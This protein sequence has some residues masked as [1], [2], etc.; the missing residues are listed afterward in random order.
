MKNVMATVFVLAFSLSLFSQSITPNTYS[1]HDD[2]MLK[3]KRKE[4]AGIILLSAGGVVTAGGTFLIIDG[5][6]RNK[7][8]TNYGNSELNAGNAEVVVGVLG[9]IIGIAS[10]SASI[11]FFVGAHRTRKKAMAI[12]LNTEHAP[13]VYTPAFS[14]QMYPALAFQI[15]LGK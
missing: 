8:D 5:L 14:R 4:R 3:S 13:L 7:R 9:T 1:R 6:N 10:M 11:P 2:Y 12:L 15:P